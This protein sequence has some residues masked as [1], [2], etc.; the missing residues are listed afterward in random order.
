MPL[1]IIG[2]AIVYVLGWV[3]V[4]LGKERIFRCP[5]FQ[6]HLYRSLEMV[7]RFHIAVILDCLFQYLSPIGR[8]NLAQ[9]EVCK[10]PPCVLVQFSVEF[11]E[12]GYV[13]VGIRFHHVH[14][15]VVHLVVS[16]LLCCRLAASLC[17]FGRG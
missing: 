4:V 1:L 17:H 16:A 5:L 12:H 7:C 11:T 6:I 15:D 14:E 10:V 8:L 9:K 2:H 13:A 3:A